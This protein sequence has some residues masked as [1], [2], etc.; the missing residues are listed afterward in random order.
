MIGPLI[1][2][3]VGLMAIA[4]VVLFTLIRV[5]VIDQPLSLFLF[6]AAV[7]LAAWIALGLETIEL[8]AAPGL[9]EQQQASVSYRTAVGRRLQPDRSVRPLLMRFPGSD[10]Y[11]TR[12]ASWSDRDGRA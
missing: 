5:G 10:K 12:A 6:V 8:G 3:F 7:P 4:S 9:P 2:A 11:P 1:L